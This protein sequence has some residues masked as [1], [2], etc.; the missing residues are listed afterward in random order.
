MPTLGKMAAPAAWSSSLD[1]FVMT[2]SPGP[3]AVRNGRP[4]LVSEVLPAAVSS[5]QSV[6]NRLDPL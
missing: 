2:S 3:F 5:K 4:A 6:H 1:Q